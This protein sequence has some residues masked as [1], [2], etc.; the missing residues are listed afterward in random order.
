MEVRICEVCLV[1]FHLF[2]VSIILLQNIWD[3]ATHTLEVL[4]EELPTGLAK[5]H[6]VSAVKNIM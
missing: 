1:A 4:W 3:Q 6:S 2:L 5:G